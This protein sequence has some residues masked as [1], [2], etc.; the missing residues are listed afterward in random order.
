[1]LQRL[2]TR[3]LLL[4]AGLVLVVALAFAWF[5]PTGSYLLVPNEA[6]ALAPKVKVEGEQDATDPGGILYVD[7]TQR[8]AT[9]LERLLPFLR[10]DGST[11]VP[12]HAVVPPG[13]SFAE[14]R[15]DARAEMLRSKRVAAAVALRQA[16]F[17]VVAKPEGALVEFV[18]PDVPAAKQLEEQDVI[19]AA[20]GK[21][22]RTPGDL[23][24]IVGSRAPGKP[25]RLR[26]RRGD[27]LRELTVRTVSDP[28][29]ERRAIIGIRVN[30][31]AQIKLPLR[32]DIELG[33][34]GG[35]SAGLAF[36]LDILEE[37]GKNVDRG[38]TVAATGE[39]ELDGSVRPIGGV[40]Q[41][42]FGVRR[43]RA[44]VFIVPA[45]DNAQVARRYAGN[46][47]VIAVES[48]QQ[49]LRQLATLPPKR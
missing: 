20:D 16:G 44:D 45:G 40:K 15:E 34:V 27:R 18:Q 13:S 39:L 46:L 37:L 36:A 9:W 2:P 43:A 31:E 33:D 22:V 21:S 10:P 12:R 30:Q 35:P 24:R 47:R 1:M 14:R 5:V 23:R 32:V 25:V 26:I 49:A 8:R 7:L 41:K 3:R 38:Y 28:S 29:E 42:T 11:L 17:A 19:V 6:Q 4:S 48:F